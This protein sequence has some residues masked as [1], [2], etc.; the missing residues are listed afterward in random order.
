M[1]RKNINNTVCGK[2]STE[3]WVII[4]YILVHRPIISHLLWILVSCDTTKEYSGCKGSNVFQGLVSIPNTLPLTQDYVQG[5][6]WSA[7]FETH[8]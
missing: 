2:E 4:L 8:K 5:I 7:T 3:K 1:K 6:T